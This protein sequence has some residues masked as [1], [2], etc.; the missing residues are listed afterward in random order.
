MADLRSSRYRR[1]SLGDDD[2]DPMSGVANLADAM[3]VFA[4]G[5]M[6][7]L[8]VYWNIDIVPT[9]EIEQDELV[10]E[11]QDI[12]EMSALASSSDGTEYVA[13]GTVYQDPVTGKLYMVQENATGTAEAG[14]AGE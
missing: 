1:H 6:M 5:L 4:C 8:V 11:V 9:T 2:L 7:A 10:A 12:N 3:L 14:A 13:M